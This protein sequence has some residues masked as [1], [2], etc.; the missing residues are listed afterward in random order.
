[1]RLLASFCFL[2]QAAQLS[3]DVRLPSYSRSVLPNGL[4]LSIMPR[5]DVPLVTMRVVVKGGGESEPAEL[6]GLSDV[7]AEMLRHGTESRSAEEFS[8]EL[9]SLGA[10]F[11]AE[12]NDQ[13][14][15]IEMEFLSKDF[16]KGMDLLLDAVTR[17]NFPEAEAGKV[18]ARRVDGARA[19]KD[20]PGAAAAQYYRSFFYGPGHPYGRPAD[21]LSYAR[22]NRKHV[23]DYHE[24]M[25]VGQN[26][27][28]A[29][30]G[31]VSSEAASKLREALEKTPAGQGYQWK[32]VDAQKQDS[33]RLA[34]VN[35]PDATQTYFYIGQ[36]GIQRNHPDR[37]ALW[38]VNTLFG[39]RFTSMLNQELRVDSGL[40]YGARSY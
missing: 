2:L 11:D 35:K 24:R 40:T 10:T 12:S 16:D 3:G 34:I 32:K 31:D 5:K 28:V 4:V 36:P 38:L 23:A 39:G 17:P 29:V 18:L 33:S 6:S 22:I 13:A 14:T 37:V 30:V 9:D 25:Y 15:V 7:T 8:R 1:M 26:M 21:E 27:I 19:M 20:N